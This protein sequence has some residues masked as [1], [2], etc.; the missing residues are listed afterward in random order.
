M[1]YF[2]G[3]VLY[4]KFVACL[5]NFVIWSCFL[6][7]GGIFCSTIGKDSLSLYWSKILGKMI[8]YNVWRNLGRLLQKRRSNH[9]KLDNRFF[10]FLLSARHRTCPVLSIGLH[11]LL[12]RGSSLPSPYLWFFH[13]G[14]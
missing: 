9:R 5:L 8:L 13:L 10:L 3:G 7:P 14:R 12:L 6:M 11:N 4:P 2:G 1:L